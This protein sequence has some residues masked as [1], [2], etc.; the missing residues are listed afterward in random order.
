MTPRPYLS[1]RRAASAATTRSNLLQSALELFATH[2]YSVVTVPRIAAQ[3][4]VSV[5]TVYSAV[6][7]KAQLF[8]ALVDAAASDSAIG[9]A[10]RAVAE[11]TTLEDVVRAIGHGTRL[12]SERHEW[13]LS[14]IYDNAGSDPLIADRQAAAQEDVRARFEQAAL[15]IELLDSALNESVERVTTVLVFFFGMQ[16]LRALRDSGWEWDQVEQWLVSQ[17]VRA[18]GR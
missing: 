9:D 10:M 12:V 6:G 15:R 14:E 11:A 2:G 1:E 8:I 13:L 4:G 18:L 17:A 3:A 16:A 7:G 5:A